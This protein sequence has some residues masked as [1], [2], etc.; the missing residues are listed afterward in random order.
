M[1]YVYVLTPR[2]A[3]RVVGVRIL[4]E[5]IQTALD[6]LQDTVQIIACNFLRNFGLS[7]CLTLLASRSQTLRF[8]TFEPQL[9]PSYLNL[10]HQEAFEECR[11]DHNSI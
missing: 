3:T 4:V 2:V 10:L 7:C 11:G 1:I 8:V 5:M 9:F 6:L